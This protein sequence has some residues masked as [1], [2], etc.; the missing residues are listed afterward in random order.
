MIGETRFPVSL[1]RRVAGDLQEILL[2][3]DGAASDIWTGRAVKATIILLS[4]MILAGCANT[5]M[6]KAVR[7]SFYTQARALDSYTGEVHADVPK[8]RECQFPQLIGQPL[9]AVIECFGKPNV[10]ALGTEGDGHVSYQVGAL[11]GITP[12]GAAPHNGFTVLLRKGKVV[13]I[14]RF[15]SGA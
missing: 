7:E 8:S 9:S 6:G 1:E 13:D 10:Y 11:Y 4:I 14:V 2:M 15:D 5:P 3:S 12:T